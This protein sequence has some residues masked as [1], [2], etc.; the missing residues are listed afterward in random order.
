VA[1]PVILVIEDDVDVREALADALGYAGLGVELAED[2]QVG[3]D[4]LHAG[5]S[6]AVI[7]LDLRMPRMSGEGFLQ[8]IRA[9]AR[10]EH[11]PVITMT[12]GGDAVEDGVVVARLRKPFDLDQLL[13]IV[14]SLCGP[15]HA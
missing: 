6:P 15:V 4:R 2:G 9:D 5:C 1:E 7:L 3:L 10:F 13:E 11:V 14:V 12:G 8:A